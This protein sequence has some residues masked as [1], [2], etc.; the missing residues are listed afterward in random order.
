MSDQHREIPPPH[1]ASTGQGLSAS[2]WLDVHF[3]A[4]RPEYEAM[5]RSVP[6]EPGW[7][8]LDAGCG[9]GNF[10]PL[11][12]EMVGPAGRLAAL[13]LAPDNVAI[14][15]ERRKTWALA[16][17][18]QTRVGTVL[19]LPFPADHFDAVWCAN[20]TQYLSDAELATALQEFRRVVRPGGL[21]AIKDYHLPAM[22]FEP[23]PPYFMQHRIDAEWK[24]MPKPGFRVGG[25]S[26]GPTLRT[27]LRQA[28]YADVWAASTLI[29]RWAP[30]RP[31][32]QQL[33][34]DWLPTAARR[35]LELDLPPA[36]LALWRELSEPAGAAAFV[37]QPDFY[38]REVNVVVVGRVV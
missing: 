17:P 33:W 7:H 31:V 13:D 3:E 1:A 9:G 12:A 4:D 2:G 34:R 36:D 15:E 11:L 10:L 19:D 38:S 16:C 6:I 26:R 21:V 27:W 14:V 23:T 22:W 30:L 24:A 29:E 20:T 25:A 32:E 18:I 5:L 8:V 28:G 35:A 37:A